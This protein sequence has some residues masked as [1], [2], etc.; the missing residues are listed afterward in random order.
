[1]LP[2]IVFPSQKR[3]GLTKRNHIVFTHMPL[4]VH[5]ASALMMGRLEGTI[6]GPRSVV[7]QRKAG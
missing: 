1:V 5:E 6:E 3:A 2:E 7:R 4:A